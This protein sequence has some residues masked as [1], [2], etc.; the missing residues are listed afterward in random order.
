MLLAIAEIQS[1]HAS[2]N[3]ILCSYTHRMDDMRHLGV[4]CGTHLDI[5]DRS[6][7]YILHIHIY[8]I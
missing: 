5:L 2:M 6:N 3:E 7:K 1:L 8:Y 4:Y